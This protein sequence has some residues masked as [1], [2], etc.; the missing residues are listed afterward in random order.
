M[1]KPLCLILAAL[2]VIPPYLALY[3]FLMLANFALDKILRGMKK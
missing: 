2:V 3:L 1:L